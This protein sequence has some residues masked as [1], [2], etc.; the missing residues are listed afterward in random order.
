MYFSL[1]QDMKLERKDMWCV[2]MRER[3]NKKK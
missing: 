1:Y 2:V 3:R